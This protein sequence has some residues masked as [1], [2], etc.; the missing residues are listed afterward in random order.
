MF[1]PRKYKDLERKLGHKFKNQQLLERAL[2]HASMRGGRTVKRDNERLEFIGDR[3]LG[4]AMVES[5]SK[6]MPDAR[7][8][9]L[10]KRYNALVKGGTCAAVGQR[11][12]L[13]KFMILSDSEESSGGRKKNTI[14]ADAVEA[15]LGAV[16]LDAG[17][18]I[19]RQVV[20]R[21]WEPILADEGGQHLDAKSVLQEWA[22][23]RGLALPRYVEV[24]RD[25]PDHA[26][27]FTTEV[28]IKGCPPAVGIGRS[29]RQAEQ[30]AAQ[31]LLEREGV[32]AE[33]S[34]N[35]RH[36]GEG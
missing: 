9:D 26:P 32:V 25:G 8:G 22:Q 10:A 30:A 31:T 27:K 34:D 1:R 21:L 33:S 7:E 12:D 23:G 20:L 29:K 35:P 4:L 5:V 18:D 19:A 17:F 3:V 6:S 2:T 15:V 16:F 14:L 24:S 28:R 11:I 36:D 13:G